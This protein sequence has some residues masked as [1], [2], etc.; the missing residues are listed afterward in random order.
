MTRNYK[1]L[2]KWG[3]T[4]LT[5]TILMH[6]KE[7]QSIPSVFHFR[8][9]K[10]NGRVFYYDEFKEYLPDIKEFQA[11]W[12]YK[13]SLCTMWN[14]T[15]NDIAL[16]A[17]EK[18]EEARKEKVADSFKITITGKDVHNMRQICEDVEHYIM[19]KGNPDKIDIEAQ[20]HNQEKQ[21]NKFKKHVHLDDFELLMRR[22]HRGV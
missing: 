9:S 16:I 19:M 22:M 5:T 13:S 10:G 1:K 18:G 8:D 14:L 2:P 6:W 3:I 4:H 12:A 7:H 21:I 20:S 17:G 11:D 15:P